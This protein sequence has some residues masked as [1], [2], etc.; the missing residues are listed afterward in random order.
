[1]LFNRLFAKSDRVTAGCRAAVC[2]AAI[3]FATLAG[4]GTVSYAQTTNGGS[5]GS[6][7]GNV[8]VGGTVPSCCT[9]TGG[10]GNVTLVIPNFVDSSA[11]VT[12]NNTA[13]KALGTVTCSGPAYVRVKT[14][15][16]GLKNGAAPGANC[17]ASGNAT[18]VNYNAVATWTAAGTPMATLPDTAGA[19]GNTALSPTASSAASTGLVSIDVTPL[20]PAGNPPLN[21]GSFN[22][23]A[24]VQVGNPI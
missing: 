4:F 22:D 23:V 8:D 2:G 15:T 10:T 9:W 14:T 16:G 1:M 11:R 12:V 17:D 24:V 3:G 20:A 18:C 5:N 6:T 7:T 13:N 19:P 21:A